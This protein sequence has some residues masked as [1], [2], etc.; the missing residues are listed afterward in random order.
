MLPSIDRF[1]IAGCDGIRVALHCLPPRLI[2]F[3]SVAPRKTGMPRMTGVV[4]V[5]PIHSQPDRGDEH[6]E[7]P[8]DGERSFPRRF[9]AAHGETHPQPRAQRQAQYD[10][11]FEYG[12]F[13]PSALLIS[14]MV[15]FIR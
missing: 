9:S 6:G 1:H 5:L 8:K 12:H 10:E 13:S 3:H 2:F 7:E 14:C 15:W 4:S 11:E